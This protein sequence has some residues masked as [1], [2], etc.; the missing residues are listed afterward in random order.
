MAVKGQEI[1]Q[2]STPIFKVHSVFHVCYLPCSSD[3]GF[4]QSSLN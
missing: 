4:Q 1:V 3:N 2:G